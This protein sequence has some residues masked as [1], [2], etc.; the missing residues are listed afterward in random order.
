MRTRRPGGPVLGC[1]SARS[2]GSAKARLDRPALTTTSRSRSTLRCSP[3][4]PPLFSLPPPPRASGQENSTGRG[5]AG[6][7]APSDP[8]VPHL[9]AARPPA[10]PGTWP[11]GLEPSART[12]PGGAIWPHEA[13]SWRPRGAPAGLPGHLPALDLHPS[14]DLHWGGD[15]A[16]GVPGWAR[17]SSPPAVSGAGAWAGP[18]SAGLPAPTSCSVRPL[19]F[20]AFPRLA[21]RWGWWARRAG[22]GHIPRSDGLAFAE[23]APQDTT[24]R[25]T[26]KR[27]QKHLRL[28][29]SSPSSHDPTISAPRP[30]PAG[31][32]ADHLPFASLAARICGQGGQGSGW[33]P[34]PGCSMAAAESSPLGGSGRPSLAM[35]GLPH[36]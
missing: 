20:Q 33:A 12:V 32:S 25:Q 28:W 21:R 10:P 14:G 31:M 29:S 24:C 2:G 9:P 26:H 7:G 35:P 1:W 8:P 23:P 11:A 30:P 6:G 13:L 34:L 16:P 19:G 5:G 18:R 22:C 27:P 3:A 36:P 17:S 15:E 4:P